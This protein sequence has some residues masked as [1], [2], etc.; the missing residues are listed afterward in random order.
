[1]VHHQGPTNHNLLGIHG[2]PK[3]AWNNVDHPDKTGEGATET[4][5][6]Y[7]EHGSFKFP[8]WHR[9]YLAMIEVSTPGRT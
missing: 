1:M 2:L 9:P 5:M 4:A 6:G 3:R 7:C 8:T